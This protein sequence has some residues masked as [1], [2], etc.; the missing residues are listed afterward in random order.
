MGR[1]KRQAGLRFFDILEDTLIVHRCDAFAKSDRKRLIQHP[2]FFF[3]DNGV[4]NGLLRNFV[5]SPDRIGKLFENLIH[6]QILQS[7]FNSDCDIRISSYR[8]EHGAEV[9]FIVEKDGE[10]WAIEVKAS[11]NVGKSDLRGLKNFA[12]FYG[13]PLRMLVLYTG[14]HRKIIDDIEIFPWQLALKEI[15]QCDFLDKN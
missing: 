3:F 15:F 6:S 1:G 9:D 10:V 8:T 12:Q 14:A 13:K 7:S 5:V 11:S 2:R 4:L